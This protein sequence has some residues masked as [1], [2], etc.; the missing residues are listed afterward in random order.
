M[1]GSLTSV[2]F[3]ISNGEKNTQTLK[4]IDACKSLIMNTERAII[5]LRLLKNP[6]SVRDTENF[7]LSIKDSNGNLVVA[8]N[9]GEN[10]MKLP[11]S[12][13]EAA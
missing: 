2:P 6:D 4:I 3:E 11:A 10:T 5:K 13:F 12:S 1:F 9:D 8:L 7:R